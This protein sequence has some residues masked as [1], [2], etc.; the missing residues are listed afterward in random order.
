M[1]TNTANPFK[2]AGV[3]RTNWR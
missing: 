3:S 1:Q 2:V